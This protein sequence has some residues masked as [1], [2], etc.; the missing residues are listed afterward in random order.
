VPAIAFAMLFAFLLLPSAGA[1][2]ITPDTAADR[3]VSGW[4]GRYCTP[5]GCAGIPSSPL[6]QAAG[7]GAASLAIILLARRRR[8]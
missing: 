5:S 1:Q 4:V 6:A 7:F 2:A 3:D 8:A